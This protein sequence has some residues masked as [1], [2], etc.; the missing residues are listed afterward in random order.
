MCCCVQT[1]SNV[2]DPNRYRFRETMLFQ[3]D[4]D[5]GSLA[6]GSDCLI[7]TQ[8]IADDAM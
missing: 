4:R 6:P 1:N 2:D 3:V 7:N 5:V 8:K